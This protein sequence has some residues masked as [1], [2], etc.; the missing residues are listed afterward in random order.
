VEANVEAAS[1]E[2][3]IAAM[4]HTLQVALNQNSCGLLLAAVLVHC[5][6]HHCQDLVIL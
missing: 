5:R 3:L 2:L 6:T 4:Q 1:W